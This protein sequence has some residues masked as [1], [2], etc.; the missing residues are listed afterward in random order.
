MQRNWLK[1]AQARNADFWRF[2]LRAVYVCF[3]NCYALCVFETIVSFYLSY[4][5]V[6]YDVWILMSDD[7]V[8]FVLWSCVSSLKSIILFCIP[9]AW[10]CALNVL[11]ICS[12]GRLRKCSQT[13]VSGCR[14][15]PVLDEHEG[16][17]MKFC[18][19]R[20]DGATAASYGRPGLLSLDV[21]AESK[22][23]N[24]FIASSSCSAQQ[25]LTSSEWR[26]PDPLPLCS[27]CG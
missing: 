12:S 5:K 27:L 17:S 21:A 10:Y 23:A 1:A 20:Q 7:H 11:L 16:F 2:V 8:P 6:F 26:V 18:T 24:I 22:K 13:S 25:M 3:E 15:L 19:E 14:N 4:H 9:D